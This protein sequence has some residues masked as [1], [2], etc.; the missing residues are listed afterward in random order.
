LFSELKTVARAEKTDPQGFRSL[1]C[2]PVQRCAGKER[3]M[4]SN[5]A[6][7]D[8]IL[9]MKGITKEFTGVRA[10]DKVTLEV[11]RGEVH[12]IC[13]ENGAGKQR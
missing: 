5:V 13:G 9:E 4:S 12:A 11:K 10:L 7:R 3:E 8:N 2:N 6:T 1:R